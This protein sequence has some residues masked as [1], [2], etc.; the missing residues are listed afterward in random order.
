[1]RFS[2]KVGNGPMNKWLDFG[3]DPD[4]RLNTELFSGFVT[5]GRYGKWLTDINLLLI[6]IRQMAALVKRALAEIRTVPV[7]PVSADFVRG[8]QT[9]QLRFVFRQLREMNE[10]LERRY[11]QRL[12]T[13]SSSHISSAAL[14]MCIYT[15]IN[16]TRLSVVSVTGSSAGRWRWT[17]SGRG[18]RVYTAHR[19]WLSAVTG[20]RFIHIIAAATAER[21]GAF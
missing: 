7:L 17:M 1:M 13:T 18:A 4:N 10:R 6:L 21:H 2:G 15:I 14:T 8:H 3:S 19:G 16:F 20:I 12:Y 5:I 11:D 9:Q